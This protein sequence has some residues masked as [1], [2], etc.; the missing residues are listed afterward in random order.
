MRARALKTFEAF[1]QASAD[2][3][4]KNAVLV[5][6]TGAIFT[7]QPSGFLGKGTESA[8]APASIVMRAADAAF[9]KKEKD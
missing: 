5:Q 2:Q 6:A 8:L 1:A 3:E 7:S 9:A 4:T